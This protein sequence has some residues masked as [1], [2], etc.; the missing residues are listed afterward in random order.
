MKRTLLWLVGLSLI[1]GTLATS[2]YA[3][4]KDITGNWQGTLQA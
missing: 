4:D 1:F 2:L 3:Q